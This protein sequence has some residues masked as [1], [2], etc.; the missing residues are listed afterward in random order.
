MEKQIVIGLDVGGTNVRIGTQAKGRDLENF[1]RAARAEVLSTPE[2]G[3]CLARF[4]ADY[5]ARHQLAS[6]V[7][8]IAIGFPSTLSADRRTIFQ[9]PNILNMDNIPMADILE[10]QLGIPVFLERDVNL[11]FEWDSRS[12]NLERAGACVGIYFGT[13][14]GNAI[15]INGEPL[16][17]HNGCAGEIGHIPTAGRP[18][19]CGCGNLGCAE[20]YAS[21]RRLTAIHDQFFPKTPLPEIFTAHRQEAVLEAFVDEIACVVATEVNILDPA[22]VMLGGGVLT[23]QDFPRDFLEERIRFHCRKPFPSQ[24]LQIY[25]SAESVQAGVRGALS[26]AWSKYQSL[27]A[28]QEVK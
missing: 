17:G 5:L 14:I 24:T 25:Y 28:N 19:V 4:I 15:F 27:Q 12:R 10:S 1:E 3:L 11:I 16:A 2:S 7:G 22:Y 18:E 9:T 13:G 20:C 6:Q 8:A 23:M 26:M 21:G